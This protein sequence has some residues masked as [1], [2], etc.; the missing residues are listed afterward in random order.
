MK[1]RHVATAASGKFDI[2][3]AQEAGQV[4]SCTVSQSVLMSPPKNITDEFK[5]SSHAKWEKIILLVE[6]QVLEAI[7]FDLVVEQPWSGIV[8]GLRA[9]L[10]AGAG[11]GAVRGGRPEERKVA[12]ESS[13]PLVMP[14]K[15]TATA[16]GP[17]VDGGLSKA[18]VKMEVD[19]QAPVDAPVPAETQEPA[20]AFDAPSWAFKED[21]VLET[22][23]ILLNELCVRLL[24]ETDRQ[25]RDSPPDPVPAT[26]P[27][28]RHPRAER[29]DPDATT[30]PSDAALPVSHP[31]T[32]SHRTRSESRPRPRTRRQR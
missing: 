10:A 9:L 4:C 31:T 26:N 18:D 27:V 12:A 22:S 17:A 2:Q 1:L 11:A 19:G 3:R 5:A 21:E 14:E 16:T 32:T 30:D 15:A 6:E 23:M 25:L 20:V 8:K 28:R 13:A 29:F 7:C 24:N